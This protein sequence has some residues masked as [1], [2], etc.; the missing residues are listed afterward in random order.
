MRD[1]DAV[2]T[3]MKLVGGAARFGGLDFSR[4]QWCCPVVSVEGGLWYWIEVSV[5]PLNHSVVSA[6]FARVF[7]SSK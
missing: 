2:G 6:F 4:T 7:F 1:V 3:S 5:E